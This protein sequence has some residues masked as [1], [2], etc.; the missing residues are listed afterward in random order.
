M[1]KTQ[2]FAGCVLLVGA[3]LLSGC[4]SILYGKQYTIPQPGEPSATV[5]MKYDRYARLDAMTFNNK[6]CYAG[7]T[8]LLGNGDYVESPVAVGRELI[9][10]YRSEV[11]GMQCQVPFSFTPEK[12]ATYT[13]VNGSWSEPRKGVLSVIS[14][15]QRF[16]GVNVVK[17]VGDQES[18]EPVQQLRIET[19]F[20][21]LKWVK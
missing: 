18:V 3:L 17:K 14:P 19:G 5:R 11:G 8:T 1:Y 7:Y 2:K 20:A 21:C 15:D 16:C 10:T 12:D 9:L 13:V 6:G 4:N